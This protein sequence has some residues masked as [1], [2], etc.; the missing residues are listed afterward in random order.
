[1]SPT[2]PPV[3]EP[4]AAPEVFVDGYQ[5]TLIANGNVKFTFFTMAHDLAKNAPERRIVL[6]LT[7]PIAAVAGMHQAIGQLLDQINAPRAAATPE[8]EMM[9]HAH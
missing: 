5:S 8:E 1:M 9:R 3:V 4:A 2:E 7:A 6:R